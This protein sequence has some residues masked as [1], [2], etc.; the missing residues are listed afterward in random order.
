M[1]V[2]EGDTGAV[3]GSRAVLDAVPDPG[4]LDAEAVGGAGEAVAE[5]DPR[6]LDADAVGE[7]DEME[8]VGGGG[9]IGSVR[10]GAGVG[11][12]GN[13]AGGG[14]LSRGAG[15]GVHGEPPVHNWP[16]AT[17]T[18][19][20]PAANKSTASMVGR[21]AF[22]DGPSGG[23]AVLQA[24]RCLPPPGSSPA[25]AKYKARSGALP[26]A[27]LSPAPLERRRVPPRQLLR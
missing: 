27:P 6:A 18:R 24:G 1:G 5:G 10:V 15:D 26:R 21:R 3:V 13:E 25:K 19:V 2:T 17:T 12:G 22:I 20:S 9:R 8:A 7:A 11:G 14:G 23:G 4:A 16:A